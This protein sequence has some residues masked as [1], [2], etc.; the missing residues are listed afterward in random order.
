M[1]KIDYSIHVKVLTYDPVQKN[2]IP[3]PDVT[4]LCEHDG[5]LWNP[6]LYEGNDSTDSNG[7][8][9]ITVQVEDGEEDNINPF[10][11]LSAEQ[12]L[13]RNFPVSA[14]A[15][16]Q[17]DLPEEWGTWHFENQRLRN[18]VSYT[19]PDTPLELFIGLDCHLHLSYADFDPSN[20]R[21]PIALPADTQRLQLIDQDSFL[22]IDIFAADDRFKGVGL[23]ATSN[24]IYE[25]SDSNNK[26]LKYTDTWPISPCALDAIN[27][28]EP[29]AWIDPPDMPVGTLCT[30]SFT[31]TG[32]IA[33]DPHGFVFMVGGDLVKRFYPDGTLCETIQGPLGGFS[34]PQ[35]LATDQYRHLFV[36]DTG[37][38]RIV[39]MAL[40]WRD[41]SNG[42]Y[43]QSSR[44]NAIIS[45]N[46][47]TP[48]GLAVIGN[49]AAN[50]VNILVV[51]N[52]G[53]QQVRLY[54]ID[55]N[56]TIASSALMFAN[57]SPGLI[58]VS[59]FGVAGAS[60]GEFQQPSGVAID[61]QNRIYICDQQLHR[62][63]RWRQD[64]SSATIRYVLD[65]EWEKAG[66]GS[67]SGTM[68]F[69]TPT[70]MAIDIVHN[71]AYV[72]ESGNNR[73]QRFDTE[74]AAHQQF[75]LPSHQPALANTFN[76]GFICID[77]RGDV[78][79]T[80]QA[81]QRVVRATVFD[82]NDQ[83]RNDSSFPRTL[84]NWTANSIDL[85]HND[86]STWHLSSPAYLE[87]KDDSLWVCDT[88][89]GRLIRFDTVDGELK[90]AQT[91]S[92]PA[93]TGIAQP[94]GIA[95]SQQ[96][97]LF[98]SDMKTHQIL[99]Y[100]N[101]SALQNRHGS[102]GSGDNEY[103]EPRGLSLYEPE[104]GDALLCI[105]DKGNNRIKIIKTD[106]TFVRH[107]NNTTTGLPN[108][109]SPEA[110]ICR[111]DGHVFVAD[112]GNKRVV[113][114]DVDGSYINVILIQG[115]SE[116]FVK[117]CGIALD[118]EGRL[119][120]TD[121]AKH[122]VYQLE[123]N[124]SRLTAKGYLHAYW[125]M[126]N[127]I[128]QRASSNRFYY[129]ELARQIK[130]QS[131]ERAVMNRH[132]LLAIADTDNHRIRLIR[133]YTDL[134][135]N[136]FETG[137]GLFD[138]LPDIYLK[139]QAKN[140]WS[141]TL[142]LKLEVSDQG[143]VFDDLNELISPV[144]DEFSDDHFN[145]SLTLQREKD[146]AGATNV[147]KVVK[148]EQRWLRHL[149]REDSLEHRWG[150]RSDDVPD[151]NVDIIDEAGS[152]RP[153]K[154]AL[155]NLASGDT[156]GRGQDAWDDTVIAH[157]MAHWVQETSSFPKPPFRQKAAE[158]RVNDV[159]NQTIAILEGYAEYIGLFWGSQF[160]STDRL[161]G[162]NMVNAGSAGLDGVSVCTNNC[163]KYDLSERTHN[164]ALDFLYGGVYSASLPNF[165]TPEFGL[166]NE[167]YFAN[168]IYQIHHL[169][170]EPDVLY[171]DSPNYWYRFNT[172]I[173]TEQSRLISN[174]I[175]K[176][177][178]SFPD[179]P[180]DEE[181]I[182]GSM[183]Y[184]RQVL[185]A[186]HN[187]SAQ[188]GETIQLVNE[189]NNQLM[190]VI[191][192][193]RDGT[194]TASGSAINN[195]VDTQQNDTFTLTIQL[196]DA[197]DRVLRGYQVHIHIDP[198]PKN[199]NYSLPA[200]AGPVKRH[201]RTQA[202]G[203]N[204]LYRATNANGIINVS[205][206]A[207]TGSLNKTDNITISYQPDFDNDA[208]FV[209]PEKGD[210]RFTLMRKWYLYELRAC[211]KVWGRANNNF[212][213]I[214]AKNLTINVRS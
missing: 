190:P 133:T 122:T 194:T 125:D 201:G 94:T 136:A 142:G 72:I 88:G 11:T 124:T 138:K 93:P 73:I 95:I 193:T 10:F 118:P 106:G 180:T 163:D 160:G 107:L 83:L 150:H 110:V 146:M 149:T 166:R 91:L 102:F 111:D 100:D 25:V 77:R 191:T 174:V 66:G 210:D 159:I 22:G 129:P 144:A 214:V 196:K 45:S 184:Q 204:D 39:C 4:L 53:G 40:N 64:G 101:A 68:E 195:P 30:G 114:Y 81:N 26:Y 12:T 59:N 187:E 170:A 6:N 103:N 79:L 9:N 186:A 207:P 78:F 115:S 213:A 128:R 84:L 76:A 185:D 62:V 197:T 52:T 171:A 21:N 5:W 178:R 92:V 153:W 167:G 156:S 155:F 123:A 131:P 158:H 89:R 18:L 206:E 29:A 189:L 183:M 98:A 51:V 31:S 33:V 7:Q 161:R 203:S 97:E 137:S 27:R 34:H 173:D 19:S 43:Q 200:G 108:L 69:N 67:G 154:K 13:H 75:W 50:G 55:D 141:E 80:D 176:A 96:N 139:T 198:V 157:E 147:M 117:P 58:H 32:A 38:N 212:G 24:S 44:S 109:N 134:S 54:R 145:Y 151:L 48:S 148:Q 85:D 20:K 120:V 164:P 15:N 132:G 17:F 46:I 152:N 172:W 74:T 37:N 205:I 168:S 116:V 202:S 57:L 119:L 112:T 177:L 71:Y 42:I 70:T 104:A 188:L 28:P 140:D 2:L 175:R 121:R 87:F 209:R 169:L 35:A 162:F 41:G 56:S 47:N 208:V 63:S 86:P 199:L 135:L 49:T 65:Q 179:S 182:S 36:A 181:W 8:V 3:V 14:P 90:P 143:I 130:L 192:L 105:A 113:E 82:E 99:Q 126:H 16:Q 23:D 165:S 211:N 61:R 60:S 127:L 1:A